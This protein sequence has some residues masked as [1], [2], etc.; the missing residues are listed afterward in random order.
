MIKELEVEAVK[1]QKGSGLARVL[2]IFLRLTVAEF[3]AVG[4]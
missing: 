1:I 4:S 2:F 3:L